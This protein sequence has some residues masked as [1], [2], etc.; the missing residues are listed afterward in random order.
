MIEKLDLAPIKERYV[1]DNNNPDGLYAYRKAAIEAVAEKL[2][3]VIDIVNL[4]GMLTGSIK[5]G[6]KKIC[7][8]TTQPDT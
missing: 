5:I 8:D 4:N 7:S 2:N 6:G 3:E 1:V